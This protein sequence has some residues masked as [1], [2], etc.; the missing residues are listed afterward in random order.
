MSRTLKLPG[1]QVLIQANMSKSV[2]E[3]TRMMN[4]Y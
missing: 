2:Q 3:N 1:V 4:N